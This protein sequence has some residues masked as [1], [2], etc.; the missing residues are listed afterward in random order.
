MKSF[1]Q[2]KNIIYESQNTISKAISGPSVHLRSLYSCC[3]DDMRPKGKTGLTLGFKLDICVFQ[4]AGRT[5]GGV[6]WLL[7]LIHKNFHYQ[8]IHY[9][10]SCIW[11]DST[12]CICSTLT[13]V[14]LK[15][16]RDAVNRNGAFY[17]ILG[18]DCIRLASMFNL[19]DLY[20]STRE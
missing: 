17:T 8:P 2:T 18:T 20:Q 1:L 7:L 6:G 15:I 9:P 4:I 12:M 10:P 11:L 3:E 16:S 14:C 19:G 5:W 13:L